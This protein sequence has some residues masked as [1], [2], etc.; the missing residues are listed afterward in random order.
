MVRLWIYKYFENFESELF[1]NGPP[2]DTLQME[3]TSNNGVV[4]VS[5]LVSRDKELLEDEEGYREQSTLLARLVLWY[6]SLCTNGIFSLAKAIEQSIKISRLSK[7]KEEVGDI[8]AIC[9]EEFRGD[10]R[11]IKALYAV[12]AIVRNNDKGIELFYSE[13]GDIMIQGI[14]SNTTADVRLHRR[15]VSL[16]ADLAEYQLVYNINL[17]LPFL[18]NCPLVKVLFDLTTSDDLDLQEKVVVRYGNVY[19]FVFSDEIPQL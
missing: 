15:L 9:H 4:T 16:I 19:C 1:V 18:R 7:E 10:E 13:G 6:E 14:L 3:F 2:Y 8:C 5:R 17:E 11:A 12:S